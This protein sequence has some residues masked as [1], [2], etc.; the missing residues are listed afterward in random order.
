MNCSLTVLLAMFLV[1]ADLPPDEAIKKEREKLQGTWVGMS[2]RLLVPG[3]TPKPDESLILEITADTIRLSRIAPGEVKL[4]LIPMGE[5]RFTLDPTKDPK[6]IDLTPP[7]GRNKGKTVR[8]IYQLDGD[9]LRICLPDEPDGPRPTKLLSNRET[10]LWLLGRFSLEALKNLY[11]DTLGRMTR[12]VS[13]MAKPID[14]EDAEPLLLTLS[15]GGEWEVTG[16]EEPLASLAELRQYLKDQYAVLEKKATP[17]KVQTAVALR[18][19]RNARVGPLYQA[20]QQASSQGFPRV[21]VQVPRSTSGEGRL[22]LLLPHWR[23]LMPDVTVGALAKFRADDFGA[24]LEINS[25]VVDL[26]RKS[27]NRATWQ[28]T[29]AEL[30]KQLKAERALDAVAN[31]DNVQ[32][33]TDGRITIDV[34]VAL[35]DCCLAAGFKIVTLAPDGRL[36]LWSDGRLPAPDAAAQARADKEIK[37]IYQVVYAGPAQDKLATTLRQ[38]SDICDD[39]AAR[40]VLLREAAD[41]AGRATQIGDS[42]EALDRLDQSY[43]IDVYSLKLEKFKTAAASGA[44]VD[45]GVREATNAATRNRTDYAVRFLKLAD[46]AAR[47]MKDHELIDFVEERRVLLKLPRVDNVDPFAT[48]PDAGSDTQKVEAHTPTER[49]A[50]KNRANAPAQTSIVWYVVGASTVGLLL[51][52]TLWWFRRGDRAVGSR[53][54]AVRYGQFDLPG[55]DQSAPSGEQ[56]REPGDI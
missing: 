40:F 45:E 42:L 37:S 4:R 6:T 29:L 43:V 50:D 5:T 55:T 1:A 38:A 54:A 36:E 34:L 32:I 49:A 8:G 15:A 11:E 23:R 24:R 31:K 19:D 46:R 21:F 35:M 56:R 18:P 47:Q 20:A 30:E 12:P 25:P 44:V 53:V 16:R 22:E 14:P 52:A 7:T 48:L 51:G 3:S 39:P 2:A 41:A 13:H 26:D 33:K 17:G 27:V 28:E 10:D 9:K